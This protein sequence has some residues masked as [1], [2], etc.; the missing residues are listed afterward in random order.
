MSASIWAYTGIGFLVGLYFLWVVV[1]EIRLWNYAKSILA[2][3]GN[4]RY[5]HDQLQHLQ[6]SVSEYQKDNA[7]LKLE[8]TLLK[9]MK[10]AKTKSKKKKGKRKR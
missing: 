4:A 7:D 1:T 8:N 10:G 5:Q 9:S 6:R 3:E 2:L